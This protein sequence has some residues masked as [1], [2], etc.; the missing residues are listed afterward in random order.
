F[1]GWSLRRGRLLMVDQVSRPRHK[2]LDTGRLADI[3]KVRVG[4]GSARLAGLAG[5]FFKA[6]HS[7]RSE[8]EP[9]SFCSESARGGGAKPARGPGDQ[10]PSVLQLKLHGCSI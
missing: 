6:I 4:F 10:D 8:Q 7:A 3:E 5:D 1:R 9:G 2:C